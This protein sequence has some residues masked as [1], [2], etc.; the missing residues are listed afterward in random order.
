MRSRAAGAKRRWARA[1]ARCAVAAA[2]AACVTTVEEVPLFDVKAPPAPP[3]DVPASLTI[4]FGG[5]PGQPQQQ[6]LDDVYRNVLRQLQEAAT[7]RDPVT[8]RHDVERLDALLAQFDRGDMPA[9]MRERLAG[10]RGI[11]RGLRFCEQHAARAARLELLPPEPGPDGAPTPLEAGAPALGAPLR[12]ELRLPAPAEPTRL[13]G[14][15]DDQPIA[16]LVQASVRD[17]YVEGS[18]R[19]GDTTTVVRLPEAFEW[20]GGALLRV[21]VVVDVPVVEAVLREV[22]VRVSLL[23]GYV[24]VEGEL[25]P[26]PQTLLATATVA[27]WP[28]GYGVVAKAPLAELRAALRAFEP[29]AFPRAW[30][31]AAAVPPGQ[32]R[33]AAIALLLDQVRFGRADQARVATAAL[34]RMTGESLLVGDRE[35]WLAWSQTRR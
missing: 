32:D 25:A 34:R 22:S 31:A 10:Y 8:G 26:V 30:L 23:P 13:C 15:D 17:T 20:A 28:V 6:A 5:P 16:F 14:A 35:A 9:V 29:R 1:I 24:Q 11:A 7:E 3:P 33:E 19:G 12:F 2:L 21:P 27:Q 4:P 18:E